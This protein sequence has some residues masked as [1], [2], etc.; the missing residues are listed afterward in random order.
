MKKRVTAM[1]AVCLLLTG[2]KKTDAVALYLAEGIAQQIAWMDDI[3]FTDG[4]DMGYDD[5]GSNWTTPQ[6]ESGAPGSVYDEIYK[7]IESGNYRQAQS[8]L[9]AAINQYGNDDHFAELSEMLHTG[10]AAEVFAEAADAFENG[11]DYESAIRIIQASGLYGDDVDAEIAK[12]QEYA[13]VMLKE[14]EPVKKTRGIEV[15][16]YGDAI[17]MDINGHVYDGETVIA[18]YKNTYDDV[19]KSESDAYITYYL[20]GKYRIFDAVLYRTYESLSVSPEDWPQETVAKIYGDDV[21]LYEGPAI[22]Q[23]TYEEYKIHADISGVRELKIVLLGV[24][25]IP[26][27]WPQWY[28]PVLAIADATVQK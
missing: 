19:A 14:F 27:T 3:P 21:L 26:D 28:S 7:E 8:K 2:C 12:Y 10:W 16:P 6:T 13:P 15:Y 23:N 22:T 20:Y 18:P 17:T 25:L 24:G 11:Y 9:E 4:P 5:I 1:L